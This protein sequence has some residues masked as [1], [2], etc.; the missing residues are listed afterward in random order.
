[1][2]TKRKKIR[3]KKST[4]ALLTCMLTVSGLPAGFAPL[5]ANAA[6][7]DPAVAIK[8]SDGTTSVNY[9]KNG[10]VQSV[11]IDKNLSIDYDKPLDAAT[12]IIEGFVPGDVL[13]F[14]NTNEIKG[15]YNAQNGILKLTGAATAQQY[16]DALN[17]VLFTPA[18]GKVSDRTIKFS[19]GS[20]LPFDVNGHFYEYIKTGSSITW[21]QAV[22][23]A[24]DRD[25]FGR[26]GYLV[27]I[28]TAEESTFV[29]EKT[30]KAEK[31]V[32]GVG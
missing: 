21:G 17:S 14:T 15:E 27:T 9:D 7:A 23:A 16:I 11:I 29:K 5:T 28:T 19:L 30:A 2:S 18:S 4:A 20:A 10:S 25:Y 1:M 13:R 26:E 24:K 22:D 32:T 12:V 8:T 31:L 6:A 3:W